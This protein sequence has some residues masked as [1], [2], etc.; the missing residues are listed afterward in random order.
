ML[1]IG[2][3]LYDADDAGGI[4][5]SKA[6]DDEAFFRSAWASG[7]SEATE[8]FGRFFRFAFGEG[9]KGDVRPTFDESLDGKRVTRDGKESGATLRYVPFSDFEEG[10]SDRLDEIEEEA[11]GRLSALIDERAAIESEIRELRELQ[12]GCGPESEYAFDRWQ[13]QV[14]EGK[15]RAKELDADI[16]SFEKN[17]YELSKCREVRRLLSEMKKHLSEGEHIVLPTYSF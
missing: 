8:S 6:N 1:D 11:T 17:D 5:Y 2:F 16:A 3:A 12:R 9:G 4:A 14:D 10:V 13:R 7:W 15:A